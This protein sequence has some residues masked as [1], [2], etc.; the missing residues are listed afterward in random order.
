MKLSILPVTVVG[1]ETANLRPLAKGRSVSK[2]F[3]VGVLGCP[4]LQRSKGSQSQRGISFERSV[5]ISEKLHQVGG[6]GDLP[7]KSRKARKAMLAITII[8]WDAALAE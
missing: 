8:V 4:G 2:S 7:K 5:T 6:F 1:M 3:G